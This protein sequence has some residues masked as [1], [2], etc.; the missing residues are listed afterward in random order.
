MALDNY[1]L[2]GRSG[3]RV[4]PLALGTMIFGNNVPFGADE[5][6][7]REIFDAYVG[8]GGNFIDTAIGYGFGE[9]EELLGRFMKGSRDE[10][11]VASKYTMGFRKGDPNSS[12]NHRKNMV[13]SLE[14]S[15]QQLQTDYLDIFYV[16]VWEDRTPIDEVMRGLDDLI[17]SG[18]VQY[19]AIS[20]TPAW[21]AAQGQTMAELRGWTKFIAMQSEYNLI[22]RSAEADLIPMASEMGMTVM[23]WSPLKMGLLSGQYSSADLGKPADGNGRK[24]QNIRT[25]LVNQRSMA[26]A[27]KV[28][29]IAKDIGQSPSQVAL[30]WL[31]QQDFSCLPIVGA[32]K[33]SHFEDNVAALDFELSADH[34]AKLTEIS[35]PVLGFPHSLLRNPVFTRNML[36]QDISI[37]GG[38]EKGHPW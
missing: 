26:I 30:R 2:L 21:R 37:E 8:R 13:Q 25:G 20:D 3:L 6:T 1:T 28:I 9:C 31:L 17:R 24:Q 7:A 18:K 35:N 29:A 22:D 23:P 34:M 36:D 38:Y 19:I 33:M 16:H 12:G 5:D 32:R 14:H 15:L 11:V 4:S 27:D 10:L